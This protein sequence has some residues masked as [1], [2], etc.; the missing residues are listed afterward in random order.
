MA[1]T[2]IR[3]STDANRRIDEIRE[4]DE[5]KAEVVERLLDAYEPED[6]A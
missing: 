1:Y 3:I 2:T 4:K 6:E 5:T